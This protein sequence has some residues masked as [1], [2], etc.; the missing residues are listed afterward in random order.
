L[1]AFFPCLYRVGGGSNRRMLDK[2]TVILELASRTA[3]EMNSPDASAKS[4]EVGESHVLAFL[5]KGR[6]SPRLLADSR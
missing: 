4:C 2:K 5:A 3:N 6:P 1:N